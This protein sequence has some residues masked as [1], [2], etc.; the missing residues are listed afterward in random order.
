[1][2][3]LNLILDA[4]RENCQCPSL[5]DRSQRDTIGYETMDLIRMKRTE[6]RR[7]LAGRTAHITIYAR[8][9]PGK[10]QQRMAG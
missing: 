5:T 10:V 6:E 4:L 1:M 9:Y 3:R 2:N 7:R 8:R